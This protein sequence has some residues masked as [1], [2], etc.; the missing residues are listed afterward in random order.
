MAG[1]INRRSQRDRCG[2]AII[3][4]TLLMIPMLAFGSLA[5]DFGHVLLVRTQTQ[6]AVDAAAR[7]AAATL[8]AGGT[9]SA[10]IAAAKSAA[11]ANKVDGGTQTLTTADVVIG[12]WTN[13]VFT[14]GGSPSNAAFVTGYR[15][16][17]RGSG[18]KLTLLA[19]L[20]RGTFD[21]SVS[22]LVMEVPANPQYGIVAMNGM[23]INNAFAVDSY[24]ST[25]GTYVTNINQ[26]ATLANG[27][28]IFNLSATAAIDG[29]LY[30][31]GSAPA[32]G[33]VTGN[34][35]VLPT[36]PSLSTLYPM[37][38]T[39]PGAT[40]MGNYNGGNLSLTAGNYSYT[41]FSMNATDKLQITGKVNIYVS[42]N[43]NLNGT[44]NNNGIP[45][46]LAFY[47]TVAAGVNINGTGIV[48]ALI[49]APDSPITLNGS[50]TVYGAM[51]GSTFNSGGGAHVH[52]DEALFGGASGTKISTVQ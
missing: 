52:E 2:A 22:S 39:A 10:A 11:A 12:N 31:T 25:V 13:K 44:V 7:S 5:V 6:G 42:G 50:S 51:I 21:L 32:G 14:A 3:Y 9:D 23:N 15:T 18:V 29:D 8:L 27:G 49:Y 28:T 46:N 30:Y 47:N 48:F 20:G 1:P 43:I 16:A 40:A 4:M 38:P 45:G 17:A 26:N 35:S 24:N 36:T 41:S 34:V 37:V 33:I 19:V